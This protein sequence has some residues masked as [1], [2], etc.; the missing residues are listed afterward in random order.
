M[1][2]DVSNLPQGER[3]QTQIKHELL[4]MTGG[5]FPPSKDTTSREEST[6]SPFG[7]GA[8]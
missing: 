5:R 4:G 6:E 1:G 7:D 8:N 3:V 2:P